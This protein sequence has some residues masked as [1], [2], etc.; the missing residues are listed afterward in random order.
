MQWGRGGNVE[1]QKNKYLS[2]AEE[3]NIFLSTTFLTVV[4]SRH[5]K[6]QIIIDLMPYKAT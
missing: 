5:V 2:E 4:T 6:F 3:E 1:K